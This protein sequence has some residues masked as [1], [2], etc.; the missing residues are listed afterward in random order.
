VKTKDDQR[1]MID[2][3]RARIIDIHDQLNSKDCDQD[4]IDLQVS[5]LINEMKEYCPFPDIRERIESLETR[6]RKIS[7]KTLH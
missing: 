4:S 7:G 1:Q 6:W 3:F 2:E 5:Q